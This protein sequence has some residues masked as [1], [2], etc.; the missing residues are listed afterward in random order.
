MFD[1]DPHGA[2]MLSCLGWYGINPS[3][4]PESK[5]GQQLLCRSEFHGQVEYRT[6][7]TIARRVK[8]PDMDIPQAKLIC[9]MNLRFE[10]ATMY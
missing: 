9:G 6:S 5:N 3:V 1:Y 2:L 10:I 8:E 7:L 4:D